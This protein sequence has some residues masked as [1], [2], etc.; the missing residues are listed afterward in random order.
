MLKTISKLTY[1]VF[2]IGIIGRTN[3]QDIPVRPS[4]I[5]SGT[6]LGISE[7]LRNLPK[8]TIQE[9]EE[10][11][12]HNEENPNN[13]D[14]QFREYPFASTAL[15]K[16]SDP[17]WQQN[18]G[19]QQTG[20]TTMLNINGQQN[21]TM[22]PD[23]CGDVGPNHYIQAY[24]FAYAIYNKAG[25]LLAGPTNLNLIFGNVT[26]SN[27]NSGDPVILYD[28]Q[29][30]RWVI[31][32]FSLCNANKYVLFAVS[33]TADPTGSYYKY[34]FDTDD[35]PDYEKVGV[36]RDGYYMGTNTGG[37]G[38]K[39]I[40]VVERSV[41]LAGGASPKMIGFDNP[42]RPSST[43]SSSSFMMIPPVDN[44][45][46]FAPA[47]SPGLFIAFNDDAVGGGTDQLWVYEL[48]A[49]W[50]TTANSTLT[51]S[52]QINVSAFDSN[53][54]TGWDN[55]TQPGT[56]QK[57]DG[58]PIIVMNAPQYRNFGS[59]QTL[60]CCHT[61]DVDNTDH[62]G[63]RWYEL[64]RTNG[65]WSVRQQGTY[66][67]DA[68]S[69]WMASIRLNNHNEIGLGYS[70]SSSS[71]YPGVRYCGQDAIEYAKASGIM[72]IGETT[73]ATGAYSQY[74]LNRWGDYSS[75]NVDP[76]DERVFWYTN[77]H[78][79]SDHA[80]KQTVIASF[81]VYPMNIYVDKIA[82]AGG[83][84]TFASPIQTV[85]QALGALG[86]GTNVYVKSNTYDEANPMLINQNGLWNSYNGAAIVK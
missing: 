17:V 63:I 21:G 40:Y 64:R 24:N 76:T 29:A 73:I 19:F 48:H 43:Q 60:V 81:S 72:N 28:D 15:P 70:I 42:W 83:N 65:A 62:A 51:R 47:G 66:A 3:A 34:S 10:M 20:R 49:D 45:G 23:P 50:T 41:M 38:Q 52:Q 56:T 32:E 8:M 58:V 44:D 68:N 37:A 11:W 9:Q 69:R 85:T 7:P 16:G 1:I 5:K 36:W 13:E 12:K 27:C 79:T 82:A 14:L 67:P 54:G 74:S 35:K 30:D 6:F 77:M 33:Q 61:V 80:T 78:V 2:L 39:D 18:D 31:I 26:G 55:I 46:A 71:V 4:L 53:F 22:P 86:P 59:Y 25:N 75:L 84:G 57:L